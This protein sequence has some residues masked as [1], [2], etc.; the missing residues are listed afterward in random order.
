MPPS[1]VSAFALSVVLSCGSGS[2]DSVS[3]GASL[4]YSQAIGYVGLEVT[5]GAAHP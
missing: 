1:L 4:R 5:G 3:R 2:G